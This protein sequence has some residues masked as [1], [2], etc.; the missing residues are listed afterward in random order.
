MESFKLLLFK[1]WKS[2]YWCLSFYSSRPGIQ[3]F[4][5]AQAAVWKWGW[6]LFREFWL[7]AVHGLGY[8]SHNEVKLQ[9]N[10]CMLNGELKLIC[11]ALCSNDSPEQGSTNQNNIFFFKYRTNWD[12]SALGPG[13]PWIPDSRRPWRWRWGNF[14]KELWSMQRIATSTRT[15]LSRKTLQPWFLLELR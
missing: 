1:N 12:R 2:F 3:R 13:G 15:T 8:R 7:K 5:L 6:R 4:V 11:K 9:F 14:R 10:R